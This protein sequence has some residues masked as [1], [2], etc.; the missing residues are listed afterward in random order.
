M[1]QLSNQV[2]SQYQLRNVGL[3]IHW[4]GNCV[5]ARFIPRTFTLLKIIAA[6]VWQ[7]PRSPERRH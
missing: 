6:T 3:F 7:I 2:F 1:P 4:P 5:P